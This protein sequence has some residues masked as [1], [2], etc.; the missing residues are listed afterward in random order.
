[1]KYI[2]AALTMLSFSVNAATYQFD[3]KASQLEWHGKKISGAHHGNVALQSG[4]VQT[5]DKGVL[6]GGQ[7]V[8][9]L[10]QLTVT[11][12]EGEYA[13]KLAAH[14]KS[15]DFFS[16]DKFPE[17][18]F[19]IE[20]AKKLK[21]NQ[22]QV[23]GPLTIK[24]KSAP[25]TFVLNVVEGKDNVTVTGDVSVDRTLYDVRYGSGKFYD[26]KTLGDKMIDDKFTLKLNLVAKK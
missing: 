14:L 2:F 15:D 8:V 5:N 22:Y 16:A 11:D 21:G 10:S 24:G 17:V 3:T 26:P 13:D 7:V 12:M 25:Q 23:S 4:N 6:T 18:T 19:T 1:M 20:S 9:N